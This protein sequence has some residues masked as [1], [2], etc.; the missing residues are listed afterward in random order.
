MVYWI[1]NFIN[2]RSL[3]EPRIYFVI[4]LVVFCA[5]SGA[6]GQ[7]ASQ[8][9]PRSFEPTPSTR[10][11][12][13][14]IPEGSGPET[15]AGADKLFVDIA[16]VT[17]DGGRPELKGQEQAIA[18][19]LAGKR[20]SAA[21]LFD[22]ARQLEQAYIAAGYGLVRVVLPAQRLRDGAGL[23]LFVIDGYIER[24]DAE[25]LPDAIRGRIAPLL[26][27]L[28]GQRG[29]TLAAIGRKLLLAGDTPG[30]V[31]RST[32]AAGSAPGAT[33][34]IVEARYQPVIGFVSIDNTLSPQLGTYSMS[35]GADLNAPFGLGETIYLRTSGRPSE[36]SAG[37]FAERP[38]NRLLAAGVTLPLGYDGL[39]ANL[40]VTDARTT[41]RSD[42]SGLDSNS[43]FSRV[44]ARLNYPL[45]RSREL[46]VNLQTTFDAEQ[47]RVFSSGSVDQDLSEDRLRVLRGGG[48]VIWHPPGDGLVTV[49]LT[50][51]LGIGGLGARQAPEDP[52]AVPLS[53]QG[54]DPVFQKLEIS[55]GYTQP[56][57]PHLATDFSVQAQTAF[58]HAMAN[59]EQISIANTSGLSPLASGTLQ[60]DSGFVLR[61]ELQ[62]PVMTVFTLPST[63]GAAETG[64]AGTVLTP[65][66]FGAY[67]SATRAEPTALEWGTTR[68][69]AYG[70]GM[71]L[72]AV[73]RESFR[74]VNLGL[75]WGRY[76]LG[77]GAG[78][79]S[80]LTFTSSLQF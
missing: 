78:N 13:I 42:G 5:F 14:I 34:L 64:D 76:Q 17:I 67:G 15:P 45:I 49:R 43:I 48:G 27:P 75:E 22:A 25:A 11:G 79:G 77:D 72:G 58:N 69:A 31:L 2:F 36:G 23:R 32:L 63:D 33:V 28:V 57:L 4:M 39:T 54:A 52:S 24:V 26:A 59:A 19:H 44:S 70:L 29:L 16:S 61:G 60:G 51:S 3:P 12:E 50:G 20:V 53:R 66:L 37:L 73:Q 10:G 56:L 30:T 55:A 18:D 62:F 9:T 46:A 65:Y 6:Y 8:I 7:S 1:T 35:A 74:A 41:P 21:A 47:E 40:E 38:R 80:R 71:R 68:G